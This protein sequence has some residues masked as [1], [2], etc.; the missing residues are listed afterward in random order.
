MIKF[1]SKTVKFR[2]RKEESIKESRGSSKALNEEKSPSLDLESV[3]WD[4]DG[5]TFYVQRSA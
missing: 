4:E 2:D 1:E 5:G 3:A